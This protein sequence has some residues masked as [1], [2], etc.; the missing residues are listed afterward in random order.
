[1]ITQR[2][3]DNIQNKLGYKFPELYLRLVK[4]NGGKC[5]DR[6]S[7][8]YNYFQYHENHNS[9]L[10]ALRLNQVFRLWNI[11]FEKDTDA[12]TAHGHLTRS[13]MPYELWPFAEA[14]NGNTLLF[15]LGNDLHPVYMY[16][17]GMGGDWKDILVSSSLQQFDASVYNATFE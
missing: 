13:M 4:E 14:E 16:I 17:N 15:D 12:Y 2:L 5:Y 3:I 6:A 10:S 1:M 11:N 9:S 8:T 7:N